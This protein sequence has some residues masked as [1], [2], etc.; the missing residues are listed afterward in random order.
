MRLAAALVC[1]IPLLTLAACGSDLSQETFPTEVAPVICDQTRTCAL[2][3]FESEYRD[4]DDCLTTIEE[5]FSVE[6][7]EN[8]AKG[9]VFD[10]EEAKACIE[11]LKGATCEQWFEGDAI[12]DCADVWTCASGA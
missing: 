2:G 5:Q 12:E 9:C 7:S 3:Y 10:I 6:G 11:A 8:D 1:A 4:E